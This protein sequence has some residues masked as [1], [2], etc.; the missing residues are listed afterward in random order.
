MVP[1]R[2]CHQAPAVAMQVL[3]LDEFIFDLGLGEFPQIQ[4]QEK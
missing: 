3:S 2:Q 4:F 1:G